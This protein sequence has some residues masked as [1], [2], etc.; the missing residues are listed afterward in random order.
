[1]RDLITPFL[2]DVVVHEECLSTVIPRYNAP[3]YNADLAI[4]RFFTP[5]GFLPHLLRKGKFSEKLV[6]ISL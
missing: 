6:N 5:K 4:T 2:A 1:M 3:R